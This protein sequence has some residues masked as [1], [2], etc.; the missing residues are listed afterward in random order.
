MAFNSKAYREAKRA[1]PEFREKEKARLKAY[2]ANNKAKVAAL[3]KEWAANNKDKVN[4][5]SRDYYQA[6]KEK[7]AVYNKAWNEANKEKKS[8]TNKVWQQNNSHIL[9]ASNARYRA[10]KA[11]ATGP[12]SNTIEIKEIYAKARRIQ[13]DTGIEHHVDHIVPI[14]SDIVCGLHIAC[15][16]QILKANDN[17]SKSNNFEVQ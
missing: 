16:L 12:W 15:N 9:N 7:V 10:A 2:R 5:Y 14:T 3:K 8:A 1:D 17:R 4:Q 6:N 11:R 13:E